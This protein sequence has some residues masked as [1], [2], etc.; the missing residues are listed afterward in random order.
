MQQVANEFTQSRSSSSSNSSGAHVE[1]EPFGDSMD[2]IEDGSRTEETLDMNHS[3]AMQVY[4]STARS[5]IK[6]RSKQLS[7]IK[8]ETV[9]LLYTCKY[10][11][12][13]VI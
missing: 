13:N 11:I 8:F 2:I 4:S 6:K 9:M 5:T 1:V 10:K 3:K 12:N 7:Y